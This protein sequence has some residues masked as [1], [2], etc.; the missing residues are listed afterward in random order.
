VG[1]REQ[2]LGQRMVDEAVLVF[3]VAVD[4]GI[5]SIAGLGQD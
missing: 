2:G 5:R 4:G 3:A 1:Y